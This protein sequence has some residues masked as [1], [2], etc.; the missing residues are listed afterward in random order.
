[1]NETTPT[2]RAG[3]QEP[4]DPAPAAGEVARV[5]ELVCHLGRAEADHAEM[6]AV[7]SAL[8]EPHAREA[9]SLYAEIEA[10][11]ADLA[12]QAE[13]GRRVEA[14]AR[15]VC[16]GTERGER[17]DQAG[18]VEAA[19]VAGYGGNPITPWKELPFE[20]GRDVWVDIVAAVFLELARR[21]WGVARR[22]DLA[23]LRAALAPDGGEEDRP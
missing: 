4:P 9:E 6:F 12:A 16:A 23:A 14:A 10:A 22:G 20:G 8:A 1:M 5:M 18:V 2:A 3:A 7:S 19:Y 21:G 17:E 13:R 15:Q 11:L